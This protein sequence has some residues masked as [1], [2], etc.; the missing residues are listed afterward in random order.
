MLGAI[1]RIWGA[2]LWLL[3]AVAAIYI[4][5]MLVSIVYITAFRTLGWA[6]TPHA[7][8]FIEYGFVY[9]LFLGSPWL[10]RHR[11]HVYIELLTAA[12]SDRRRAMLSRAIALACAA[13][14]LLWTWYSARL[15][16]ADFNELRYDELRAQFD[17]ER[18]TITISFPIGFFLMGIEFARFVFAREPMHAGKAGI[19]SERAELEEQ[20]AAART[21]GD[22]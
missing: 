22:R 18:W 11:G 2:L 10:I 14:C 16:I 17:Y 4:G 19:A 6:Y 5:L 3:M 13:V 12:V 7:F 9:T 15:A 8:T 20:M 1:D 21:Q